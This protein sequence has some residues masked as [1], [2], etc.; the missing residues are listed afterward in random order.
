M[1]T[2]VKTLQKLEQVLLNIRNEAL[3]S[4]SDL[5]ALTQEL[6]NIQQQRVRILSNIAK[7]RLDAIQNESLQGALDKADRNAA[8]ILVDRD[9]QI[10]QIKQRLEDNEQ[11]LVDL[12]V[13]RQQSLEAV[14][15]VSTEIAE[16]ETNVQAR[17]A[18]DSSYI[19][20][21][22]AAKNADAIADQAEEKAKTSSENLKQKSAPYEADKLFMYLWKRGYG[23][24]EYS[25]G[26]LSRFG[27]SWLAKLISYED[28]RVNYWNLQ[29]IP[30][31][32]DQ[33]ANYCAQQAQAAYHALQDAELLALNQAGNSALESKLGALRTELDQID[34]S[35]DQKE[36][37][38][39]ALLDQRGEYVSGN[40]EYMKNC[41]QAL[42]SSIQHH[43]VHSLR[44][45]VGQTHS[46]E[47]DDQ[48]R[49]LDQ[50]NQRSDD[51]NDD[52]IEARR[53][54]DQKA[55]KLRELEKVRRDFKHH[56]Y[57]DIR[58]GFQNEGLLSKMFTEFVAGLISGSDLWKIIQRHQR[59]NR[60]NP[61]PDF[62]SGGLGGLGDIL[63][64]GHVGKHR[65]NR[66]STWHIP[67]ARSRRGGNSGGFRFPSSGGGFRF[68][69]GGGRRSGGGGFKT[70]G[71]F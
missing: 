24:T 20:L 35:I 71:G 32:L 58:S 39:N 54:H 48:L 56:R 27:D 65:R 18:K 29:E 4:D 22:D 1:W 46:R 42:V 36:Y 10:S 51:L 34:D 13:Q 28:L 33:H 68:P 11:T 40:D 64:G 69:S 9:Q 19:G 31:R 15:A 47:D 43:D 16:L 23:T 66:S 70:G 63:G 52:L 17:L 37:E 41:V 30:K 26:L 12:E 14:N 8:N 50:L 49:L 59:Y 44:Y 45:K 61:L 6:A 3:R 25:G 57:D 5:T 7:V 21:V 67:T 53:L 62:G 60:N 55:S 38:I 2:G